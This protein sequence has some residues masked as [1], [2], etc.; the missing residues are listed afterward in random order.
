VRSI[1][2]VEWGKDH[3]SLLAY[4]ETRVVD[5]HGYL[6]S[7]HLRKEGDTYPTRLREGAT[8]PGHSD[9]D[10]L[11]DL[12][13]EGLIEPGEGTTPGGRVLSAVH[14]RRVRR[15]TRGRFRHPAMKLAW[16]TRR[17]QLTARGEAIAGELRAHKGR[18]GNFAGFRP[19]VLAA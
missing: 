5:H 3:W 2:L 1:P 14:E 9:L 8:E 4:V 12:V 13:A 15:D 16:Q 11:A 6:D 19:T 10:C 18:G 7:R 17:Y